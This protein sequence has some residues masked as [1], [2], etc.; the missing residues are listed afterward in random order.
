MQD[1]DKRKLELYQEVESAVGIALMLSM[2]TETHRYL[3][4]HEFD[5]LI[6]PAIMN[7]QF[8]IIR[9]EE[10]LPIA[11]ISWALL[12]EESETRLLKGHK[13]LKP[14]EWKSGKNLWIVDLICDQNHQIPALQRFKA[15]QFPSDTVYF[16][17]K[18]EE[19]GKLVK[20]KLED[21]LAQFS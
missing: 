5:W 1:Q 2:K 10:Y 6:M 17:K 8:Q 14:Q 12:D 11:F 13:K 4:A 9:T 20:T 15:D 18:D 16:P 19:T 3:F 7:N 21:I